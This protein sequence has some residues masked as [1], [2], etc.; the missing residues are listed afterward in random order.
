MLQY[1]WVVF[2]S[3][4]YTGQAI[5]ERAWPAMKSGDGWIGH[6]KIGTLNNRLQC[7]CTIYRGLLNLLC[8]V[9]Q[10]NPAAV[11]LAL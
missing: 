2:S 11:H 9:V 6:Y 8:S 7:S 5:K 1:A 3:A 10:S 4:L